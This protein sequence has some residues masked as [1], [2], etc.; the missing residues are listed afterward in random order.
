MS[1]NH[2]ISEFFQRIYSLTKDYEA[3]EFLKHA[4]ECDVRFAMMNRDME[5]SEEILERENVLADRV[6]FLRD[7]YNQV[8]STTEQFPE[9][10]QPT[11]LY[12]LSGKVTETLNQLQVPEALIQ[13]LMLELNGILGRYDKPT[14]EQIATVASQLNG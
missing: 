9:D 7:A 12:V 1:L 13:K 5:G 2:D 14:Q 10:L 11:V 6:R 4:H 3:P 8:V